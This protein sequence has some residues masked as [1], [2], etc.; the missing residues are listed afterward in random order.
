MTLTN[1]Y[2]L[3]N[4]NVKYNSHTNQ[5]K[6]HKYSDAHNVGFLLSEIRILQSLTKPYMYLTFL[7]R[8][9]NLK[10]PLDL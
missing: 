5:K 3:F 9:V 7:Y 2:F 6:V 8:L 10:T 4:G 1:K